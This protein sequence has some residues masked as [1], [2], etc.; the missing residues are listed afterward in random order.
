MVPLKTEIFLN[1]I[2]NFDIIIY[3]SNMQLVFLYFEKIHHV[4]GCRGMLAL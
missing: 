2:S 3:Y 1:A 4:L